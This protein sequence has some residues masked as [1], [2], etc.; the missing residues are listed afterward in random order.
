MAPP[1]QD[2]I[3]MPATDQGL[4]LMSWLS[5]IVSAMIIIYAGYL[6]FKGRSLDRGMYLIYGLAGLWAF[7][8]YFIYAIDTYVVDILSRQDIRL[9][10]F[11]PV[12]F[13]LLCVILGALIR[14]GWHRGEQ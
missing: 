14:T 5:L 1:I 4:H 11:R 10:V 8:A 3:T 12:I 9:F 6:W 13:V 2:I 7:V